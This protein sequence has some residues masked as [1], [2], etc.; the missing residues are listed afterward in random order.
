MWLI[1]KKI[2]QANGIV[3]PVL[4]LNEQSEIW[5]FS[6]KNEAMVICDAFRINSDSGHE[7]TVVGH[8]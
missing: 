8:D 4:I 1:V 5:E 2:K 3:I 7:Y 6:D